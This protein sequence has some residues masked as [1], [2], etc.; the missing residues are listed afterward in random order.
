MRDI[1]CF[2][3]GLMG[4]EDADWQRHACPLDAWPHFT[5]FPLIALAIHARL[6]LG[7][8][9]PHHVGRSLARTAF[10]T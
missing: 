4:M 2:A 3:E 9:D 6:W 8:P 5:C 10:A 1:Y 7:R